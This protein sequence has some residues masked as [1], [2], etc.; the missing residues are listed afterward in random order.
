MKVKIKDMSVNMEL[1]NNGVTFDVYENDE[2]R[3]GD[4]RLGRGKVE[5]CKGKTKS[6]N[7][8]QVNWK[9]LLAFFDEV[10]AK[11]VEKKAAKKAVKK[12]AKVAVPRARKAGA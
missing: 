10:A 8:V 7:G 4:L 1:G 3:L 11:K 5:W 2:T 9:E 6:G 12:A